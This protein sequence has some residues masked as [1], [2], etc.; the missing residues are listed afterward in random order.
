M[1]QLY[2]SLRIVA[3]IFAC[4]F[5]LLFVSCS[6]INDGEGKFKLKDQTQTLPDSGDDSAKTRSVNILVACESDSLV[7]KTVLPKETIAVGD[8]TFVLKTID[9]ESNVSYVVLSGGISVAG[10]LQYT[11]DLEPSIYDFFLFAYKSADI[12]AE[13]IDTSSP[14]TA[15]QNIVNASDIAGASK[16]FTA[17]WASC[18]AQ[19]LTES[20]AITLEFELNSFGLNGYGTIKLGGSYVD[21]KGIV[22]GI[23][24]RIYDIY[25]G[26]VAMGRDPLHALSPS[27]CYYER[28]ITNPQASTLSDPTVFSSSDFNV[29][30]GSYRAVVTLYSDR[31]C[32]DEI[33]YWSDYVIVEPANV[34]E[35]LNIFIQNLNDKDWN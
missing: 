7:S 32:S 9:G 14:A 4:V 8:L 21:S 28:S 18:V 19:D 33:G 35:N 30:A 6:N 23:K 24:V 20:K 17:Y 22:Y 34:S 5:S 31:V 26:E 1:K 27:L 13:A 12:S 16:I 15:G 10:G 29:P 11:F 3:L 25:T 2:I